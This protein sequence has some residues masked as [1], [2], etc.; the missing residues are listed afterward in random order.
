MRQRIENAG[1]RELKQGY[2][3]NRFPSRKFNGVLAHV[4][5]TLLVY[6]F[7]SAYKTEAGGKIAD[8]GLRRLHRHVGYL[9]AII[10]AWPHYGVLRV[11][12][13]LALVGVPGKG[14]RGPPWILR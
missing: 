1:F 14:T 13:V 2:K 11:N 10:Y 4:I 8:L 12:E 9:A 7:V 6:N 3:I 5:I